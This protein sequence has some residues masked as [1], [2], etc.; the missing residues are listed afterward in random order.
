MSINSEKRFPFVQGAVHV[1]RMVTDMLC[2]SGHEFTDSGATSDRVSKQSWW[3]LLDEENSIE[4]IFCMAFLLL[5][6][7]F[8]ETNASK[9][10]FFRVIQETRLQ[11]TYLLNLQPQTVDELWHS[12][13]EM[14]ASRPRHQMNVPAKSE[15]INAVKEVEE[16]AD[17]ID[18]DNEEKLE[19]KELENRIAEY[20]TDQIET[21]EKERAESDLEDLQKYLP[22]LL[23]DSEILTQNHIAKLEAALP[24][25]YQG[26]NWTLVFSTAKHG[27][28]MSR[29]Y[30]LAK[31]YQA[32]ILVIKD[33]NG[34]IFGGFTPSKW[35]IEA[36]YFG[37]GESFLF[38]FKDAF[39][40][41]RWTEKNPYFML[42]NEDSIAM[43][44]G[45]SFGLFLDEDLK[46][47]TSGPCETYDNPCLA[48]DE[49][50]SS[51]VIELW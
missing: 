30:Q 23:T 50:F 18:G 5:D 9:N 8:T 43:G 34:V 15:S 39:N 49:D 44:G 51:V 2:L 41:Y 4:R 35:R 13:I 1:T 47:G 16:D 22:R 45:G 10:D 3:N 38:S 48:S 33:V 28:N 19:T 6:T 26:Y 27:E 32:T 29:L 14:R 11:M 37:T 21:G 31:D 12:W 25:S 46:G 20:S 17:T 42:A 24:T 40:A 36:E 7:N